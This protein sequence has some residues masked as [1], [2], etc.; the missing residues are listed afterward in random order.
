MYDLGG[1]PFVD[2]RRLRVGLRLLRHHG[3]VLRRGRRRRPR[4][5]PPAAPRSGRPDPR[6]PR[7]VR[8]DVRRHP[9]AAGRHR[10]GLPDLQRRGQPA[11]VR[12]R[13]PATSAT[14]GAR[15]S[16]CTR[17]FLGQVMTSRPCAA[18]QGFGTVIPDPCHE[19]GGDGR[20]RSRRS[21]KVK[22]PPGVDTGTRIQLTGEGEVGP[23][24][25]PPGDLYVEIVER[26]APA[27]P[28]AGRRPALHG[29]GAD[30]GRRAGHHRHA[31]DAG[32]AAP[33]RPAPGR[34][35]RPDRGRSPT[36]A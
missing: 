13:A 11:P 26:T 20:V 6:R 14:A 27:V 2:R 22:I 30:D 28:P 7:A 35:V 5:A 23:G 29:L 18:C 3:R 10:R 12:H 8:D 33:G 32:R 24:G 1:D 36:S 31:R 21:L 19:C 34:P 4:S 16:R 17:S 9:R 15:C 25:G